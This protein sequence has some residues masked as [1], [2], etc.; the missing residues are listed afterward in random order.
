LW[1]CQSHLLDQQKRWFRQCLCWRRQW[2]DAHCCP[3]VQIEA[4]CRFSV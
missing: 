3:Q 2:H 4:R 1:Q